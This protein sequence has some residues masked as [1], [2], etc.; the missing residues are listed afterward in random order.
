MRA[1]VNV[2]VSD[3]GTLRDMAVKLGSVLLDDKVTIVDAF[4]SR[5]TIDAIVALGVVASIM[6]ARK[7]T[8]PLDYIVKLTAGN[9][10]KKKLFE[11]Q[12]QIPEP[13]KTEQPKE[14][15][16]VESE[17]PIANNQ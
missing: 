15:S 9:E 16:N 5:V 12:N 7:I 10:A 14:E 4:G 8:D 13:T 17:Q 6:E 2:L 1:I 11:E 3:N